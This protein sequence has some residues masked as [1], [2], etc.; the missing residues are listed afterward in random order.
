MREEKY[1][2]KQLDE[3]FS[4]VADRT[5]WKLPIEATVPADA[6]RDLI[7]DAVT[8]FTG[9]TPGFTQKPDGS[10]LVTAEGY[11]LAMVR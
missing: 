11:Y 7:Y 9:S 8:Y 3:A 4:L 10:W 6:D 2:A 5:D 1:T